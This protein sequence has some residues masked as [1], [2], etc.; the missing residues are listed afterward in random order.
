M[1]N[2]NA[3]LDVDFNNGTIT[4]PLSLEDAKLYMRIEFSI[5]EDDGLINSLITSSREVLEKYLNESLINRTVTATICNL[6]GNI[7]LPYSPITSTPVLV[8]KDDI[9]ISDAVVRGSKRKWVES[10]KSDFIKATY[11]AGYTALTLPSHYVTALKMQVLY[12]YENRGDL[13]VAPMVKT[14]LSNARKL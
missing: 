7:Y 9:T 6:C 4:E 13:Q 2:Y 12:M 1:A 14:I 3:V 8:D 10:P 11:T 5:N